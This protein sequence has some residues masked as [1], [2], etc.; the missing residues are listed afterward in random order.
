M[1]EKLSERKQRETDFIRGVDSGG[2]AQVVSGE[3]LFARAG[4]GDL[5]KVVK[6]DGV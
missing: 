5:I 4:R 1:C 6:K 2:G 3:E